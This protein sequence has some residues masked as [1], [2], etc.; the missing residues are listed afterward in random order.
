MSYIYL[1]ITIEKNWRSQKFD[2][3]SLKIC[4]QVNFR[5]LQPT[6]ILLNFET[7]YYNLKIRGLEERLRVA[8][9]LFNFWKELWRFKVKVILLNKNIN[10]S[11]NEAESKMENPRH[12]FRETSLV[13]Q[14]IYE[15]QIKSKILMNWSSWKK[16]G[17]FLYCLFYPK[18]ISL[19]FFLSQCVAH[20]IHFQ[21]IHTFIYQKHYFIHFCCLFLKLSKAFI[22]SLTSDIKP[23]A[24]QFIWLVSVWGELQQWIMV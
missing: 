15:S 11:E 3:I 23:F 10:F 8:F 1:K 9:L 20:W 5:E 24:L 6:Q 19:T 17:H 21:N 18:E 4:Q 16:R 12:S 2:F 7:S 13:F 14:D 22:V